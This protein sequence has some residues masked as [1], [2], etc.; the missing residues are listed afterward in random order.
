M[1]CQALFCV[2]FSRIV[3]Q[4]GFFFQRTPDFVFLAKVKTRVEYIT[5]SVSLLLATDETTCPG[6]KVTLLSM[7]FTSLA[8]ESQQQRLLRGM[9]IKYIAQPTFGPGLNPW[10]VYYLTNVLPPSATFRRVLKLFLSPINENQIYT[11][12]NMLPLFSR[13]DTVFWLHK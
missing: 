8:T 4:F 10:G 9:T 6:W 5:I 13:C 11:Y 2:T 12:I 3:S 7:C 1:K